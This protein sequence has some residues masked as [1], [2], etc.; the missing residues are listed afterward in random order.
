VRAI[1]TASH[2]ELLAG[3][4]K[5]DQLVYVVTDQQQRVRRTVVT[6]MEGVTHARLE[7]A[8]A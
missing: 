7:R 1:L 4:T 2:P 5:H 8:G 3:D 6:S